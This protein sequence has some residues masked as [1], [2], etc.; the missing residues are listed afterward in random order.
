[1]AKYTTQVRS[2]CE[3]YAGLDESAGYDQIN[4]IIANSRDKIFDEYPIFD[5][6]YREVLNTKILRHYYTREIGL[7][8]VGLWKHFLNTKMNEIMPYYNKLYESE[9]LSFNPFYDTDYTKTGKNVGNKTGYETSNSNTNSSENSTLNTNENKNE[10]KTDGMSGT[11][12]DSGIGNQTNTKTGDIIN[13]TENGTT[14]KVSGNIVDSGESNAIRTDNLTQVSTDSGNDVTTVNDGEK[15][16]HWDYFSDTPQG[17]V[18]NLANL[19]Y[20]TNARHVTD[21]K[22]GST[23]TDTLAHGKRNDTT[24]T[25]N[26]KTN[27]I[28]DNNQIYDEETVNSGNTKNT[29][30]FNTTDYALNEN[31]NTKT[32]DTTNSVVSDGYNEKNS[33]A[34]SDKQETSNTDKNS[35]IDTLNDYTE[36]IVG[37][38]RGTS[39]TKL[40]M[41]FRDT[42]LNIDM[43]IIKEL[44][45]LFFGL[46]E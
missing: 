42:F 38:M 33:D 34:K 4:D 31:E 23:R 10:T 39:Y 28:D 16:D 3:V 29:E 13:D 27:Q 20:L 5:E 26:V 19:T 14:S 25:G 2:I 46:W 6:A 18:Q 35:T 24:N 43:M 37:K 40:L 1:M 12:K 11:V 22:T 8:T 30:K 41:E 15:N 21:D 7:E 36:H 9:L 32:Y 44:S 17:S 45:D